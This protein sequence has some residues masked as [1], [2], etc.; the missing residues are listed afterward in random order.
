MDGGIDLEAG[1]HEGGDIGGER[2]LAE[3]FYLPRRKTGFLHAEGLERTD[4]AGHH[5][6]LP[7]HEAVARGK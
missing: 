1:R 3:F 2:L 6:H 4:A 5:G 7:F